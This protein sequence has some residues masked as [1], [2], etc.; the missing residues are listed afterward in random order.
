LEPYIAVQKKPVAFE[1]STVNPADVKLLSNRTYAWG[2]S[3]DIAD[4]YGVIETV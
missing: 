4:E 1:V 3:V 2:V